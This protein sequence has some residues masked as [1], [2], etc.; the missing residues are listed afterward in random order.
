MK[1]QRPDRKNFTMRR[2]MAQALIASVSY[3][4]KKKPL[5]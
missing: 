5:L 3:P 2:S 4:A 1:G